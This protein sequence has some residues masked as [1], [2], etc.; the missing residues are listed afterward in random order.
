MSVDDLEEAARRGQ[1]TTVSQILD[2]HEDSFTPLDKSI[3]FRA[4]FR[5]GYMNVADHLLTRGADCNVLDERERTALMEACSAWRPSLSAVQR[6]LEWGAAISIA[7]PNGKG[8]TPLHQIALSSENND[9]CTICRMLIEKLWSDQIITSWDSIVD[10]EGLTPLHYAAK[11]GGRHKFIKEFLDGGVNVNATDKLGLTPLHYLAMNT[12]S[13]PTSADILLEHSASLDIKTKKGLTPL[14]FAAQ[15]NAPMAMKLINSGANVNVLT[16]KAL[17]ALH[18]ACTRGGNT[19]LIEALIDAGANMDGD[20]DYLGG[21]LLMACGRGL[22]GVVKWL[23]NRG[24][25]TTNVVNKRG[26]TPLHVA[27]RAGH[28]EIIDILL[29][30]KSSSSCNKGVCHD[31]CNGDVDGSTAASKLLSATDWRGR[32]ALRMAA[33]STMREE[34]TSR[35]VVVAQLLEHGADIMAMDSKGATPLEAALESGNLEVIKA[36]VLES[37]VLRK[38]GI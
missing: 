9:N 38:E 8:T 33:A 15:W 12:H 3:A 13:C 11:R 7:I 24:L 5:S 25:D 17:S 18:F 23:V 29:A 22:V 26:K 6:L 1:F 28:T 36:I 21:L 2:D 10:D 32:S 34:S 31:N 37:V 19:E 20:T 27:A 16:N 4:A 30:G 35:V 14:H